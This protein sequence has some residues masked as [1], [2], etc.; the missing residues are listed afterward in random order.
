MC[1]KKLNAA[2]STPLNGL[3]SDFFFSLLFVPDNFPLLLVSY[4]QL[5]ICNEKSAKY[6]HPAKIEC[7]NYFFF[8]SCFSLV[9]R[10]G[11]ELKFVTNLSLFV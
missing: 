11:S 1:F 6:S 2:R 8:L 3:G 5:E 10:I 7:S 9:R 4:S